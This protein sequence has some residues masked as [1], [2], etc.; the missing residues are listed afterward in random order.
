MLN[1]RISN[2]GLASLF[3]RWSLALFVGMIGFNKIFVL[4]PSVHAQKF[5]IE[6]FKQH[7]IPDFLL[8]FLGYSIPFIELTIGLLLFIGYRVREALITLGVLLTLVAYG[9]LLQNAFY[10]PTSHFFPRF[11]LMVLLLFI[12]SK[13]DKGAL[14]N[15]L[16]IK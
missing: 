15:Y 11:G 3:S 2:A 12:Y 5:F 1:A 8:M 10:D 13:E 9:H 14:E 16:K 4:S 7:W 6:G